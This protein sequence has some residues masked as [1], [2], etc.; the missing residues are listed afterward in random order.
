[1]KRFRSRLTVILGALSMLVFFLGLPSTLIFSA[2]SAEG[3]VNQ[4]WQRAEEVGI[5]DYQT[6]IV[7]TTWPTERLENVGLSSSQERVYLEGHTNR[8][9]DLMEMKLWAEGGSVSNGQG[10]LEIKVEEG[11][12]LED[13]DWQA[14]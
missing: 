10:A 4:A 2:P 11:Q 1:M 3:V 5:Y 14:L 13:V 12:A 6:N 9:Q 7:Q 8:H